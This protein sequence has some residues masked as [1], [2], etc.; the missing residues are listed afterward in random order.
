MRSAKGG[1][2][3]SHGTKQEGES[4]GMASISPALTRP[5]SKAR[6]AAAV[7][8]PVKSRSKSPA[9]TTTGQ[10]AKAS[11]SP[12]RTRTGQFA[13]SPTKAKSG[14]NEAKQAGQN[15]AGEISVSGYLNLAADFAHNFTDGLAIGAQFLYDEKI[16][17]VTV[18]TILLHEVSSTL[19]TII[20]SSPYY[21][22]MTLHLVSLPLH[23]LLN[24]VLGFF[25]KFIVNHR[26]LTAAQVPHEIGDFAIL[27]QSGCT[28]GQAMQMQAYTAIG[29]MFGTVCGLIAGELAEATAWILPFTAGGFIYIATTVCSIKFLTH[30]FIFCIA[31]S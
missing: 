12:V 23:L 27:V 3:H 20:L 29:A 30:S 8:S 28:K 18:F 2:G 31:I 5:K 9:R 15:S 7:T 10:S 25:G 21:D 16:A 13:K 26:N 24:I 4:Q 22:T 19:S 11:K 6:A 14:V 1:H 17:Y